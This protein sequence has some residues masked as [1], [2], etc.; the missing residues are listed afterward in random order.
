MT[1]L[2][3]GCGR[4]AFIEGIIRWCARH[5]VGLPNVVGVELDPAHVK[6]CEARFAGRPSIRIVHAD[7]LSSAPISADAVI[8]N[9]PYVPITSLDEREK[10]YYR[11][12]YLTARG[13][14]DLYALFFERALCCL[15]SSGRL[16]FI[17]PEKFLYTET[18]RALR[19]L[20][21]GYSLEDLHLIDEG[22]F[23]GLITYPL[24]TTLEKTDPVRATR[25]T[26]RSGGSQLVR[27]Q[28]RQDSWLPLLRGHVE[29]EGGRTLEQICRRISCG[30]ATGADAVF[31]QR[32]SNLPRELVP[33]AYPTV[34][35]RELPM[36]GEA[37]TRHSIL[38][39]Y[40]RH[41]QLLSEDQL[42]GLFAHLTYPPHY[43]QLLRRT[44]VARKPWY[45]FHENPPLPVLRRPKILC[46]DIGPR[47]SFV[48][49]QRGAIVPRHSVYY[50]VPEN[51]SVL[52]PLLE[53]LNAPAAV[54]WL[55]A[56]CQRAANG[57]LRLQSSV[58]KRL[59]V[60]ADLGPAMPAVQR[61]ARSA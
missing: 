1:I 38:V 12:A 22:T 60:P 26:T 18:S 4:G 56:H 33:Y 9:P 42:G 44:C 32:T 48:V 31:V 41:G 24:I 61:Q 51:P 52:E 53:Y 15:R 57:Y 13:R 59:P 55:E 43:E 19:G 30:V 46:K 49:D 50:I 20:L 14:F 11:E 8:G 29:A 54:S 27:L 6:Y 23:D 40:D 37:T 36:D 28:H 2:D 35:G 3:P 34:S 17:T 7:F 21:S 47:P 58:L 5:R 39:P 16:V 10:S 45:A 25:V